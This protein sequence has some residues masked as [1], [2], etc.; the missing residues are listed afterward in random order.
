MN[1]DII[2]TWDFKNSPQV[3][4]FLWGHSLTPEIIVLIIKVV[5]VFL[6]RQTDVT[7]FDAV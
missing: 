5:P 2:F 7:L 6:S 1:L 3:F 4:F